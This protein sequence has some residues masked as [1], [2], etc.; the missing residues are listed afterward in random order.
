MVLDWGPEPVEVPSDAVRGVQQGFTTALSLALMVLGSTY[1]GLG[2]G[3]GRGVAFL[4]DMNVVFERFVPNALRRALG[5]DRRAFPDVP[6]KTYMDLRS[7]VGLEPDLTY[8]SRGRVVWVADAK[9]KVLPKSRHINPDLYQLHTY[10]TALRLSEGVLVYGTVS[11]QRPDEH[12]VVGSGVVLRVHELNVNSGP[13]DIAMQV[14][15][16]A[17]TFRTKLEPGTAR[18]TDATTPTLTP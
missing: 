16:L 13:A 12:H 1:L 4:V 14:R 5:A 8:L 2:A 17:D 15:S 10:C 11:R 7:R 3:S 18:S 6:P 9:Y